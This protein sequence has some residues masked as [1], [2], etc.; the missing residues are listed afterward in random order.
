MQDGYAF[1]VDGTFSMDG[2]CHGHMSGTRLLVNKRALQRRVVLR[3]TVSVVFV[4]ALTV[5]TV[6]CDIIS[7]SIHAS[8]F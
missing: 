4:M 2:R 6:Q 3:L 1:S 5:C 8:S 7:S